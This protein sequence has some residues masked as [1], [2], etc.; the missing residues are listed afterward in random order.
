MMNRNVNNKSTI[1][2]ASYKGRGLQ[3]RKAEPLQIKFLKKEQ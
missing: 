3:D 2:P 1:F